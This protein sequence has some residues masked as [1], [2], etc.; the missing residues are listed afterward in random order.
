MGARSEVPAS[1]YEHLPPPLIR[2]MW[3]LVA[4][5]TGMK[6]W[7]GTALNLG[8]SL[9]KKCE[10]TPSHKIIIVDRE[11]WDKTESD[12]PTVPAEGHEQIQSGGT[13]GVRRRKKLKKIHSVFTQKQ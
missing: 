6:D 12:R 8:R 3:Q 1:S 4:R 5:P 7:A 2:K 9:K 13:R 11:I 10:L